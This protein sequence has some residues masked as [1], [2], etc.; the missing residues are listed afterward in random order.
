LAISGVPP[1]AGFFSKD[2]I[3]TQAYYGSGSFVFILL[4]ITSVLTAIYM[5]RLYFLTFRG[6]F[7]G[8]NEQEHHLHESPIAITLPLIVLAIMSVIGGYIQFPHLFG[9][10]DHLNEFLAAAHVPAVVHEGADAAT[11]EYTLL[12]GTVVLLAVV[13]A[14]TAKMFAVKSFGGE[15]TGFKKVLA[16][17]WYV[18]ELYEN[19]IVKPIAGLSRLIEKYAEKL[20]IDGAVNGVGKTVRWGGDR[21]R[22]LQ[23]GQ[24]GFYIFIMV[25]GIVIL[26]TLSF[27]WIR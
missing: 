17:K 19:V 15:Y 26:F 14:L 13:I 2:E 18:D 23:S 6:S 11:M 3:L 10:H 21:L 25:L 8:T 27:F 20:G 12:G 1:L 24:V 9:G 4:C 5:L 16:N 7:R 22:L